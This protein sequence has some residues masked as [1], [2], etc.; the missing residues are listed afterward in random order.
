M[1]AKKVRKAVI[2]A[3]GLGTR[4]LPASKA[5]PKEMLPIVDVPTIQLVVEEAVHA[6]IEQIVVVNGHYENMMFLMEGIDLALRECRYDD[7]NDVTIMRLEYWDYVK[8]ATLNTI[9]PDGFPGVA[10]E[11]A[12]VIETSLML[13]FHPDLVDMAKLVPVEPAEFPH[14]EVF[15]GDKRWV[16]APGNLSP[17]ENSS[18]EKGALLATDSIEGMVRDIRAEFP[19]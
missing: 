13:H 5:I 19:G 4:F 10:L 1:A 6:G 17:A 3:A 11:H 15:P 9:F 14:Y 7:I 16:P 12:A 18:A 2:P 8:E